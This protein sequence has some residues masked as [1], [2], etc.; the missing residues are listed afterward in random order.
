MAWAMIGA[1][2]GYATIVL[3]L[4]GFWL[5][6]ELRVLRGGLT[7]LG[8]QVDGLDRDVHAV[9]HRLMDGPQGGQR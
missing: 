5:R 4:L 9:M 6:A 1:A 8:R 2:S 3:G 7:D